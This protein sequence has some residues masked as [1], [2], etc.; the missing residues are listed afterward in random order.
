VP[1]GRSS[2]TGVVYSEGGLAASRDR[3]IFVIDTT[4]TV[5]LSS[6]VWPALVKLG[7]L[8]RMV[9]LFKLYFVF[10]LAERKN[11]IQKE[12]KVPLILANL[13]EW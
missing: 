9:L 1:G 3:A 13:R 4:D 7:M 6:S 12:G 11:E 8:G 5:A 10:A 2:V